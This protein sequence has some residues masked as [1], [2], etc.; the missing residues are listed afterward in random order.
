MAETGLTRFPIVKRDR[1]DELIGSI[2]LNNLLSA[3]V[4]NLN[5]E[6]RRERVLELPR[7]GGLKPAGV[8]GQNFD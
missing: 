7:I 4:Q 3:R 6:R 1:P 8:D 2:S 5:A